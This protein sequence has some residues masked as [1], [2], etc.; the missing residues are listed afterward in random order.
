M[1]CFDL[2]VFREAG[3]EAAPDA[4]SVQLQ[5]GPQLLHQ[6]GRSLHHAGHLPPTMY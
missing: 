2:E 4:I 6:P 1:Q 3:G 5:G